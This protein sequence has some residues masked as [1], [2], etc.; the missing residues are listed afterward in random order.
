LSSV[1]RGKSIA[2]DGMD[3]LGALVS[4]KSPVITVE[5]VGPDRYTSGGTKQGQ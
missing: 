2:I 1:Q 4:A 3:R 5:Q